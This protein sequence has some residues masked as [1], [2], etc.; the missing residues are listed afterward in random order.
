MSWLQ[1]YEE[2]ARLE[3]VI[4]K[5]SITQ[6]VTVLN[7]RAAQVA[8]IRKLYNDTEPNPLERSRWE[9][10]NEPEAWALFENALAFSHD[11]DPRPMIQ[12]SN[13]WKLGMAVPVWTNFGGL[14][15]KDMQHVHFRGVAMYRSDN[16]T[17][18]NPN[19]G[20]YS[21]YGNQVEI[22][23]HGNMPVSHSGQQYIDA[24]DSVIWGEPRVRQMGRDG[25]GPVQPRHTNSGQLIDGAHE[26][27]FL[28]Q[29][30]PVKQIVADAQN[31]LAVYC[32]GRNTL[33]DSLEDRKIVD[34]HTTLVGALKTG[35]KRDRASIDDALRQIQDAYDNAGLQIEGVRGVKGAYRRWFEKNDRDV[36]N[37]ADQIDA[38]YEVATYYIE[39]MPTM[40][41]SRTHAR[42]VGKAMY[43]AGAGEQLDIFIT[44][45]WD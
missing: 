14:K 1:P 18:A 40:F 4:S 10:S 22:V 36:N 5:P 19:S 13:V 21:T 25:Q 12:T 33:P 6:Q 28:A 41:N 43:G 9:I 37:L 29:L 15:P 45:K 44:R 24:E 7:C 31:Q 42:H 30:I 17:A 23:I 35:S 3:G 2:G 39:L 20:Q 27:Q 11:A 38:F 16:H 26:K 34:C 8:G 32:F